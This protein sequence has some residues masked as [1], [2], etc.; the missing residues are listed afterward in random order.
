MI[1]WIAFMC[2]QLKVRFHVEAFGGLVGSELLGQR[3]VVGCLLCSALLC[4]ALLCSALLCSALL[5]SALLCSA[6]LCSALL[7]NAG[8]GGHR[9]R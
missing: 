4:S 9:S 6:L 7:R 1:G 3:K 5:C 8:C 2:E